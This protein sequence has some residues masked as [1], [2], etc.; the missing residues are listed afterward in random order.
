MLPAEYAFSLWGVIK[1]NGINMA[2]LFPD[3]SGA[4]NA[5]KEEAR[6]R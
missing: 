3:F 4:S 5:V 1:R 2:R 6:W